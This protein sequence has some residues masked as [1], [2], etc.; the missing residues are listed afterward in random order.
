MS[1]LLDTSRSNDMRPLAFQGIACSTCHSQLRALLAKHRDTFASFG[2]P[3]AERL[4]AEPV[5]DERSGTI[6]WY[7]EGSGQA[8]PVSRLAPAEQARAQSLLDAAVRAAAAVAQAP[9]QGRNVRQEVQAPSAGLELLKLALRHPRGMDDLF[10]V[11]GDLVVVNWGFAPG[12]AGAVPEDI[13]RFGRGGDE[14]PAEPIQETPPPEPQPA[15]PVPPAQPAPPAPPVPP[16]QP[17]PPVP[18]LQAGP[19]PVPPP[20]PPPPPT[21]VYRE[22]TGCLPWLAPLLLLLLLLWLA[23]AVFG[24]LPPPLP[25]SCLRL[26]ASPLAQEELRSRSLDDAE[27]TL[28][29]SLQERALLCRPAGREPQAEQRPAVIPDL[30]DPPQ[31]KPEPKPEPK[32]NEDLAIPDQAARD[33]DLSFLEGCWRCDAGLQNLETHEPIIAEYCFDAQGRGTRLI[34]ERKKQ[35]DC[36]GP[37][38]ASFSQGRLV[39]EAQAAKCSRDG[40]GYVPQRVECT[41]KGGATHCKGRENVGRTGK[42]NVWDAPFKRNPAKPGARPAP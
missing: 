36:T 37:A 33:N 38:R 42:L 31:P 11:D 18:P 28:L 4:L 2:C 6:D 30:P 7:A 29:R 13:R 24:L 19:A 39:I 12:T 26:A 14:P 5:V 17:V 27:Q 32:P 21:Y 15:Q 9:V 22:K 20:P 16:V 35:Q 40:S 23:L 10:F 8:I 41:G 1:V 34:R 25:A 3:G